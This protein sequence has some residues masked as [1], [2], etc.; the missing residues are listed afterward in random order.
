MSDICYFQSRSNSFIVPDLG[1]CDPEADSFSLCCGAGDTCLTNGLC[2]T[3]FGIHYSGGCT[4]STFEDA[5]CPNFCTSG[6]NPAM[7][8]AISILTCVIVDAKWVVECPSGTAVKAGDLCCSINQTA[9]SC[10]DTASNRLGFG[11]SIF[12]AQVSMVSGEATGVL[13]SASSGAII[14]SSSSITGW[15]PFSCRTEACAHAD[16]LQILLRLLGNPTSNPPTQG[17]FGKLSR[18]PLQL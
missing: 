1:P 14:T 9:K 7:D 11:A 16:N 15:H 5:I 12:S 18:T 2:V 4:D 3:P 6:E 13:A 17:R 10:C 8:R